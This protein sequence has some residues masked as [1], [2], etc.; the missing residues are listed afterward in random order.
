M[1]KLSPTL[2]HWLM[3]G[4]GFVVATAPKLAATFPAAAPFLEQV[5]QQGPLVMVYL[6]WST[7]SAFQQGEAAAASPSVAA[8]IAALEKQ[9]ADLKAKPTAAP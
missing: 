4:A 6:G 8:G 3:L 2:S 9:L 5:A 7:N 1:L